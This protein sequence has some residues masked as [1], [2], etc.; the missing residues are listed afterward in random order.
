MSPP[1]GLLATPIAR[2]RAM[3]A[4]SSAFQAWCQATDATTALPH[5]HVLQAPRGAAL[6]LAI[7]DF[8]EGFQRKRQAISPGKPF[9]QVGGELLVAFRALV[10]A[11]DEAVDAAYAFCTQIGAI[12]ADL[13]RMAGLP[14]MLSIT[15]IG[16]AAAPT[17]VEIER[18]S[19]AGDLFEA[20]LTIGWQEFR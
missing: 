12:W 7:L 2:L 9:A 4:A 20:V 3:L 15:T 5:L 10:M 17:R 14:D 18:R 1:T 8:G 19:Y 11:G 16:M 6:P 13:E